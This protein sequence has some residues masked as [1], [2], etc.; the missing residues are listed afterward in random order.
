MDEFVKT[1]FRTAIIK[2]DVSFRMYV[3]LSKKAK[4]KTLKLFFERLAQQEL[5]HAELFKKQ[6]MKIL[7]IVNRSELNK[8]FLLK[9]IETKF[10]EYNTFNDINKALDLAIS[11]EQKAYEDYSTL[12][13]H[14]DFGEARDT[15]EEI[16]RQE[17]RHK[18]MLQKIKLDLNNNDWQVLH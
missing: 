15:F 8:L 16:A 11:E 1:I 13:K 2:E 4:N 17:L 6:S 9:D 14:L 3:D 18:Q 10:I 12:I 7:K 5:L